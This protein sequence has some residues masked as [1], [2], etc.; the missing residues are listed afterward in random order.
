MKKLALSSLALS[1]LLSL[2]GCLI[3]AD[4]DDP[5]P[6]VG[7]LTVEWTIDGRQ[8]PLDC[9]DFGV[10]RLELVISGPED[11]EIEPLCEDFVTSIDLYE[12]R[13]VADAT[14]VDSFDRA[15]TL[16]EPIDAIDVIDGTELEVTVDFPLGSFL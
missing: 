8:D 6:L 16:T 15:A 5:P 4:D 10:D 11:V 12:G 9:I 2:P 1:A 13:Y 14:L 3:V 7:T